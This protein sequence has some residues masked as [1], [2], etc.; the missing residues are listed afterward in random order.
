M[1]YQNSISN[2]KCYK[3]QKFALYGAFN[4]F[5]ISLYTKTNNMTI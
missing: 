2:F 3:T 4:I 1:R 5:Y